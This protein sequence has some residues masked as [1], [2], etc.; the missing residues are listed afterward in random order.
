MLKLKIGTAL[1]T[2]VMLIMTVASA[3]DVSEVRYNTTT[4]TLKVYLELNPIE[5]LISFFVGGDYTRS[6]I[7]SL[8]VGNYTFIYVG[9]DC[10]YLK[11]NDSVTFTEPVIITVE[12]KNETVLLQNVTYFAPENSSTEKM[13]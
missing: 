9:Y 10:S 6:L 2:A 3:W 1:L 5:R 4:S 11:I 8:V 12:G 13:G 7:E